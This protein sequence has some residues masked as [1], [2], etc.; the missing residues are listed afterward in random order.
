MAITPAWTKVDDDID[1]L[2]SGFGPEMVES[3][4]LCERLRRFDSKLGV[5]ERLND[6]TQ[7]VAV[8]DH[9]PSV[10]RKHRADEAEIRDVTLRSLGES[11]QPVG[12]ERGHPVGDS[13]GLEQ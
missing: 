9:R 12:S 7:Q 2:A 11:F 5:D 1:L 8:P 10:E 6:A 3:S 13:D 4:A